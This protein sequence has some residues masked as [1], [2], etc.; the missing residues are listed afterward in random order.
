MEIAHFYPNGETD[1]SDSTK[2]ISGYLS[3]IAQ[4]Q[5]SD[6]TKFRIKRFRGT[7]TPMLWQETFTI[8]LGGT[9][10]YENI[11]SLVDAAGWPIGIRE[12]PAAQETIRTLAQALIEVGI[13]ELQSVPVVPGGQVNSW[14]LCVQGEE[15]SLSIGDNSDILM[16]MIPVDEQLRDIANDLIAS[17]SGSALNC[18]IMILHNGEKAEVKATLV[19]EGNQDFQIQ[20][21]LKSPG[22]KNSFLRIEM[23]AAPK[24]IPGVTGS[25][26]AYTPL[27]TLNSN[28]PLGP[29]KQDIIVMTPGEQ[30]RWPFN[31]K[32]D[33]QAQRGQYVRAIYSHYG[34]ISTSRNC[35]LIRGR[36]FSN[37]LLIE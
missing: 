16:K 1:M 37:E 28:M 29:W 8:E 22:D 34:E 10:K 17:R 4:G 25:D 33:V 2:N 18:H 20:N 12:K 30:L 26:I 15:F 21:P 9:F 27:E 24:D 36:V 31:V 19:N 14:D 23:G 7:G 13:L 11:R 5:M 6:N 32:I 35:P 3:Q